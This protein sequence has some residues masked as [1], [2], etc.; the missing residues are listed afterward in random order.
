MQVSY[1]RNKHGLRLLMLLINKMSYKYAL[2][3]PKFTFH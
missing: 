3:V 1:G 2:I